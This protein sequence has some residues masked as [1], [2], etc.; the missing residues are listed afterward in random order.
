MGDRSRPVV[1][2]ARL[3]DFEILREIGRGGMGVVYEARQASLD[4][5]VALKFLTSGVHGP[6]DLRVLI[7]REARTAASLN[8]PSI[9]TVHD[10]G[11]VRPGEEPVLPDGTRLPAGTVFLAMEKI[12]GRSLHDLLADSGPLPWE[13]V[14]AIGVRLAEALEAAHARGIVHRDLKPGNVMIV[15]GDRVKVLDFGLARPP[16]PADDTTAPTDPLGKSGGMVGTIAYMAPEQVEGNPVDPRSDLFSLG[17]LLYELA[18]GERPFRGR[19]AVSMAAAIVRDAPEPPSVLRPE[20]PREADRI[21]ARCLEKDPDRRFASAAELREALAGG[22][23]QLPDAGDLDSVA[24]LP[25]TDLSRERDQEY[26]CDGVAEEIRG[27]LARVSNLRMASRASSFRLRGS[28]L[29]AREIGRQLGVRTFLEG[30]V[31]KAG[32]RLRITADLVDAVTGFELWSGSFDRELADVFAIQEEIARRITEALQVTLS[33]AEEERLGRPSTR[34]LGAF[35]LYLRGRRYYF[36]YRRRGVEFALILFRRALERDPGYARA[37]AG[38]AD[39]YCFFFLYV[40]RVAENIAKAEEASRKALE[41]D[42]QLAEAQA[43]WGVALSIAG[44]NEEA[45]E[46]FRTATRLDPELFE[47]RYFH[48]RFSFAQGRPEEAVRLYTEAE[49]LRPEDYQ[50]PLLMAQIHSDLGHPDLA[51]ACYQRGLQKAEAVLNLTPDDTRARYMAANAL[52]ALGETERG[53]EW[54]REAIRQEPDEPMLLYNVGCIFSLAARKEE[55]LDA[56]ERSVERGL[57]QRGW[58]QH[59]SNLDAL[60]QEPRFRQLLERLP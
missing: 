3:A 49:A 43:S 19:T 35:E 58:F 20:L 31:R 41:L 11:E 39:C 14:A 8:H 34:D 9:C 57:T 55:A 32:G 25:F 7:L 56:L 27:A 13:R 5:M 28:G 48:A 60:R 29:D 23:P 26:F 59:D 12:E 33:R 22:G 54:A 18:T 1:A 24:V 21:L 50:S 17:V 37:W 16:V 40:S 10:I 52:V 51:R 4:R 15:E 36:Q 44:R 53:L 46:A 30:S 47:A 6:A 45:E 38:V 42:P 2:P